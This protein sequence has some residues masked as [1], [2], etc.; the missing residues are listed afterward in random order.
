MYRGKFVL[1]LLLFIVL[2][3]QAETVSITGTVKKTGATTGL[4]GVKV[5]L[6]KFPAISANTDA[7]GAFTLAGPTSILVQ[8]ARAATLQLAIKGSVIVF[9]TA[10][11]DVAGRVEI[12]SSDGKRIAAQD[13]KSHHGDYSTVT[14]PELSSGF[15]IMQLTVNGEQFTRTL[16]SVDGNIFLYASKND[17][18]SRGEFKLAKQ[19]ADAAT[20]DS[21]VVS[22]TGYTT[23]SIPIDSYTKQ[24]VV[25]E[26]DSITGS[27]GKCT[28]E[29]MQEIVNGYLAA[30][31]A[32]DSMKM[33][34]ASNATYTENMKA[35]SFK[36]G[37]WTT[38]LKVSF[39]RDFFDVDS[40]SAYVELMDSVSTHAYNVGAQIRTLN[41]KITSI[42]ALV[43]DSGD[44]ALKGRK[45]VATQVRIS[46]A[47]KWT[48]IPVAQQNT[49][50][51]I[52]AAGDAYLT[53]FLDSTKVK[54]PWGNP[55]ARLEGSMY[56]GDA[57]DPGGNTGSCNVGVPQ[58]VDINDRHYIIDVDMGIVDIFCKFAGSMPDSHLF[59]IENGKLRYVH[60]ISIQ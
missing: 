50:A 51:V 48:T 58:K 32:G 40:C 44:W 7:S 59:R 39:H 57:K 24:N 6:A 43:A 1:S 31:A 8:V 28:R 14:L 2:M 23:K 10:S 18:H 41:G 30:I 22:K 53:C 20:I 36:K 52:Q 42:S 5:N 38:K 15:N 45:D 9:S 26:L 21:L 37:I 19:A 46:S 12:F 16:M 4:A 55:C 11:S 27:T 47:E 13:I 56:T 49:R 35:S 17:L 33:A 29:A 34:L 54:V 3:I 25:I 60:T